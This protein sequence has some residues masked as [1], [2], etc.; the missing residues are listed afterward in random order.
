MTV[1]PAPTG[2]ELVEA[3]EEHCLHAW[4]AEVHETT[5]EGWALRATPGLEG[6][7]RSNHALTPARPLSLDAY[8][9]GLAAAAAFASEHG[10]ACG[11]QVSPLSSHP[12]LLRELGARGWVV[13]QPVVVMTGDTAQI[14]AGLA[15]VAPFG[16]GL[17]D[18]VGDEGLALTVTDSPTPEWVSTWTHCDP[19]PD[20]DAHVQTVFQKMAGTARFAHAP[21]R[22]VGIS[23]ELDGIVGLYCIAVAPEW[24]RRGVGK[25]LVRGMLAQ[26]AAPLTYLQVFGANTAGIALYRSLGFHEQYRYCHAVLPPSVQADSAGGAAAAGGGGC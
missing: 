8:E 23:V 5:S 25:W 13:Q 11:V 1:G 16:S 18:L 9:R 17:A 21:G 24:R 10:I 3:V 7:G 15:G 12:L 26:H 19:R 4:P 2:L 14:A 6:R 22:A 20:A